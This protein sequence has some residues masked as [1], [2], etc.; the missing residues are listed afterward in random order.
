MAYVKSTKILLA[1]V[2]PVAKLIVVRIGQYTIPTGEYAQ[3]KEGANNHKQI[4][5]SIT[6]GSL[7]TVVFLSN[8]AST[9]T[10]KQDQVILS[11]VRIKSSLLTTASRLML[12]WLLYT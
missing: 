7:L 6:L 9:L 1:K 8:S 12:V 4:M 5:E 11:R 2:S 10:H 3:S